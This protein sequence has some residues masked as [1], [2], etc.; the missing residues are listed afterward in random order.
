MDYSFKEILWKQFGASLDMLRN[1]ISM[2]PEELFVSNKR[3]FYMTYHT[4][5]FLDYYLTLPPD[6]FSSPLPF[7]IKDSEEIPDEALDDVIPNKFYSKTELLE[8]LQ[9]GH[10]KCHAL[11]SNLTSEKLRERFVEP[12]GEGA[13]DYSLLEILLYNMRHVQHHVGQLNLL[14]RQQLNIAPRWIARAKE[15][16]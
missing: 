3:F 5:V 4:L 11:I 8:Y 1:T 15:I 2:C 9:H 6:S 14:L 12:P 10:N 13:M 16:S 7:T